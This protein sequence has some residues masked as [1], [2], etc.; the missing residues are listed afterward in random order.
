MSKKTS[1]PAKKTAPRGKWDA[2]EI[3]QA[4]LIAD[5]FNYR[6]LPITVEQPR[7]LLPLVN[8]PLIDYTLELLVSNG[9]QEIFVYCKNH[10]EKIKEHV[11]ESEFCRPSCPSVV[12]VMSSAGHISVGDVLRDIDA[13]SLIRSD[14]VLV[15]GDVVANVDLKSIIQSHKERS[16]KDKMNIMTVVY[17]E[18]SPD[19]RTRSSEDDIFVAVDVNSGRLIHYEKVMKKRHI[20]IPLNVLKKANKKAVDL[21]YDFLDCHVS[22]CSP[23]VP[24][25]FTDNYDYETRDHFVRGILVNEEILGNNIYVN[26]ISEKYAARV[27]NLHTYDSISKDVIH[28]W[29]YPLVPDKPLTFPVPYSYSRR[30]VYMGQ[31]VTLGR[32]CVLEEDVVIGPKSNIGADT[33]ISK[34]VI[35]K[36]CK[37][38]E[39]VKIQGSYIWDNVVIEDGCHVV[40]SIVCNAAILKSSSVLSQ[41]CVISY[42]VTIGPSCTVPPGTRVTLKDDTSFLTASGFDSDEDDTVV[43]ETQQSLSPQFGPESQGRKWILPSTGTDEDNDVV[44]EKWAVEDSADSDSTF[45]SVSSNVSVNGDGEGEVG[46][47]DDLLFFEEV[48][49]SIHSGIAELVSS[50]NL[51][52]AI[53]A[54]KHAYNIPIQDVPLVVMRAILE[55]PPTPP[56]E[57]LP[58]L[59]NACTSQQELLKHYIKTAESQVAVLEVMGELSTSNPS[60]LAIFPRLLLT[61]YELDV[62]EEMHILRWFESLQKSTESEDIV[63]AVQPIVSWLQEAEEESEEEESD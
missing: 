40:R 50:D 20:N 18:A 19:H 28:R 57:L 54:S 4:V 32:G 47:D 44:M 34:S 48:R 43:Q 2:E 26:V 59:K 30:N 58:Y 36:S 45:S 35:G 1:K 15:S 25:I 7:A 13:R 17:K 5:S 22:V 41:G 39:R 33:L 62:V 27:C 46:Q 38:G 42:N 37:I 8:T 55:G 53:N 3:T 11:E 61:L 49:D 56:T 14:F 31:G 63:K 24:A 60:I 52:L 16:L 21:R 23:H 6:F 9:V 12:K 10:A 51:I 29:V